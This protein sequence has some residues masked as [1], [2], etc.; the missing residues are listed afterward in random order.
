MD[1]I[2]CVIV[3]IVVCLTY[4]SLVSSEI[5]RTKSNPSKNGLRRE[6]S[7]VAE[8]N[9]KLDCESSGFLCYF[10]TKMFQN[11][12]ET[13]CYS[14]FGAALVGL[15]GIFP[16][17][18]IPIQA[19]PSLRHGAPAARLKLLLSY[20]VGGLLGDVFLHLLPEAWQHLDKGGHDHDAHIRLGLWVIAG[21]LSFLII[22]KMFAK[23]GEF[24][25]LEDECEEAEEEMNHH[26]NHISTPTQSQT[27][28]VSNNTRKRAHLQSKN[29]DTVEH[30][31][32][33]GL[34]KNNADNISN[35]SKSASVSH[36]E[37]KE[38]S[39]KVSGYLNLA[40]NVIDNFTHGLAVAGGFLVSNKVGLI[41]TLAILLHEIP[42]EI[43]DFAILLRSGFNRWKAAKAQLLT[44]SGGMLGAITALTADSAQSAGESTAWILPFTSGGF[45]YIALVTIVPDLL[46]E[47]HP[48]ESAKQIIFLIAGVATMYLVCLVH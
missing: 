1:I 24:D 27:D 6:R 26:D 44:A 25:H 32:Q 12:Y 20:A 18:V 29:G 43:G 16:L 13:W 10:N 14:L 46:E 4:G 39:I 7:Y 38:E 37:V 3:Y 47:R 11:N 34:K 15:S 5:H 31:K 2:R 36:T 19:G 9:D 28:S 35:S 48:K 45:I 23:E 33:N 8:S 21:M 42:H 40:A 41:T 17:L 30:K 22:E